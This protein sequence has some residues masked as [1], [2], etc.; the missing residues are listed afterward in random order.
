MWIIALI[1]GLVLPS[2]LGQACNYAQNVG[3]T[4]T[5][6]SINQSGTYSGGAQCNWY[7]TAN[8]D[9]RIKLT[10]LIN[11][12]NGNSGCPQDYLSVSR[13]GR[14][15]FADGYKYC[16][17]GSFTEYSTY[18]QM[19]IRLFS[20]SYSAGGS[21]SCT[22]QAVFEPCNC[23]R[24][25]STRIVGGVNAGIN[26]FPM[27]AALHTS[28]SWHLHILSLSFPSVSNW[29]VVTAQHCLGGQ[30]PSNVGVLVGEYDTSTGS[31]TPYTALYS[32]ESFVCYTNCNTNP[33]GQNDIALIKTRTE[34][35]MNPGVGIVC[36]PWKYATNTAN[37]FAGA[38]VEVTGWGDLD[39]G[40]PGTNVQ[41]KTRLSVITQSAC[42]SAL[43]TT[44]T[45]ARQVCT[46][47]Q[48]NTDTCQR[49]SGEGLLY[50][51]DNGRLY[52]VGIVS[53]GDQ[54]AL[55]NRP[56]VNTRMT[57]YLNWIIT[58]SPESRYCSM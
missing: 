28:N 37:Q 18:N 38:T 56:S 49:D 35:Q 13:T 32:S 54:C 30:T 26:E 25:K 43:G 58:N 14:T 20:Q 57:Y 7:A 34:I 33:N 19:S 12:P 52:D 53:F 46:Y 51:G 17:Q 39:F 15:D 29:R 31:D 50:T 16:G 23:G 36:L 3:T 40:G 5:T 8:Q 27:A 10:C 21:F 24:R 4:P 2:A 42:Q 1:C 9:Y 41:Q 48:G 22:I 47:G 11:V 55:A 45:D 6:F 44:I